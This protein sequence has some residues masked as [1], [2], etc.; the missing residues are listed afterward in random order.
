MADDANP[1][2]KNTGA[3]FCYENKDNINACSKPSIQAQKWFK[4][5]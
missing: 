3:K 4:P 2:P 5:N 1:L